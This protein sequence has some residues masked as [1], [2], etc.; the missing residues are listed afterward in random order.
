MPSVEPSAGAVNSSRGRFASQARE[1]RGASGSPISLHGKAPPRTKTL[2]RS[3]LCSIQ[4]PRRRVSPLALPVV[5]V[6]ASSL[7]N[8]R[9]L[10]QPHD[11]PFQMLQRQPPSALTSTWSRHSPT[12]LTAS[13]T[14]FSPSLSPLQPPSSLPNPNANTVFYFQ[15]SAPN[16]FFRSPIQLQTATKSLPSA[17][18]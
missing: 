8:Y 9:D 7:S 11:T 13:Y 4:V 2:G 18:T 3:Q 6:P 5:G 12:A 15:F 17:L 1:K 10:R 14:L 16:N